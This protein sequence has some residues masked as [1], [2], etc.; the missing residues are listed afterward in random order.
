MGLNVKCK[1]MK[2]LEESIG[3]HLQ[4]PGLGE[5]FLEMTLKSQFKKET[6]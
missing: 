6:N 2:L 3:E 5:E 1:A 4:D